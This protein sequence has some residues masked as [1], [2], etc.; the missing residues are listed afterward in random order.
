MR[1]Q[2]AGS[3]TWQKG[4]G[5][6]WQVPNLEGVSKVIQAEDVR[7]QG[8]SVSGQKIYKLDGFDADGV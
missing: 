2:G 5:R 6:K 8:R 1:A 3:T 4:G 7:A